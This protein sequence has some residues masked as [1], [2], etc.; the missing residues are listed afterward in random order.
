MKKASASKKVKSP[1]KRRAAAISKTVPKTK[2]IPARKTAAKISG[3]EELLNSIFEN[4]EGS[5]WLV[6]HQGKLVLFNKNF[7]D[8]Y[9]L[10]SGKTPVPGLDVYRYFPEPEK[11]YCDKQLLNALKGEKIVYEP[12]YPVKGKNHYFRTSLNP[13]FKAGKVTGVSC[14]SIEITN[15]KL[16][17]VAIYESEQRYRAL[18]EHA[19]DGIF[20]VN[21]DTTFMD[22]NTSA[23]KMLGYTREELLRMNIGDLYTKDEL[24]KNP[25]QWEQL[26]QNKSLLSERRLRKKDGSWIEVEINSRLQDG[27]GFLA[28]VRDITERK[29]IEEQLRENKQQLTLFIE[30]SPVALAMFDTEMRYLATSKRW[31]TDYHLENADLLGKSHYQIVPNLPQRWKD[32]HQRCLKGAVE[33]S[34]EDFYTDENGVDHWLR[35]EIRPWYK[36]SGKIGGMVMFTEFI[37]E[38][39]KAEAEVIRAYREKETVLNRISDSVVSLDNKWRYTFLN[40]EALA[41]HPGGREGT[42]GKSIWEVHPEM[43]GTIFWD[44]YHEAMETGKVT[45]IIDYYAPMDRWFSVRLFPSP[46]GLTIFYK[47]CT[48]TKRKEQEIAKE[49]NLSDSIINSLPGAFY[50]YD[51]AG[52][53]LRWNKNFETISGY[54]YQEVS[55]MH[56]L[57]FFDTDEKEMVANAIKQVLTQG[58]SEIEGNLKR[59]DGTKVAYYFNGH[60]A[61]F[62]GR[63]YVIGMGI[64]ITERQKAQQEILLEKS[65]SESIINSMPGI[66]YLANL[67][68]NFLRWNK[69]LETVTGYSAGEIANMRLR[70]F[71]S[72]EELE[73]M[74]AEKQKAIEKGATDVESLIQTKQGNKIPYFLTSRLASYNGTPC[75]LGVGVDITERKKAE[76]LI[77]K[78][79][80]KYRSLIEQ[81]SD[82]IMVTDFHG[83]F[84]DVNTSLCNTFGY[85]K[86]E[87]LKKNINSL[88]EPEELKE[89]PVRFDLLAAGQHVFNERR[90][91]RRD[92]SIVEVEA[93]VKKVDNDYV[94]AIA[95]DVTR[96]RQVQRDIQIS[97]A[98]FR[99]AFEFS[100][101][102]MAITSLEGK[103]IKVNN[104]MSQITGYTMEEM[105]RLSF[106]DITY[107][108][109]IEGDQQMTEELLAG[110]VDSFLREKRYLHK[111][112]YP[113]WVNVSVSLVKD[114]QGVPLYFVAQVEDINERKKAQDALQQSEARYRTL[115]ENAPEALVVLDLQLGKFVSVSDSAEE[116]YGLTKEELLKIGP[117]EVSPEY[118][119]DGRLSAESAME[120]INIAVAGGKPNFEWTHLHKSGRHVP[121]EIWLVRLPS[122]NQILI[123]GSIVDISERKQVEQDKEHARYLLNERVKELTTLY[124]TGRIL[125]T[126]Q[127]TDIALQEIADIIPAGWQFP[128]ICGACITL[129]MNAFK[130]ANFKPGGF[131]Q[132]AEFATT[133]GLH[134]SIEVIYLEQRPQEAEGPFLAEERNLINMLAEMIR[135]Y[136]NQK[137]ESEELNESYKQLRQLS[138]HLQTIREEERAIISR[139]IHDEL[140]QQL[141]GL[142]MDTAWLKKKV[143]EQDKDAREKIEDMLSLIDSTVTTVRRISSELRPGVLDDLGLVAALEWQS[144]E[145]EKRTGITSTFRAPELELEFEKEIAIGIF[146]IYQETL[147]NIVRHA[148]ATKLETTLER[149]GNN[150]ILHIKDNGNGFDMAEAKSKKTLGLVG[151]KE[152]ALMFNGELL[153]ESEKNRGTTITVK[154]PLTS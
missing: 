58:S 149:S 83:N 22:V 73:K 6:D 21:P 132:K 76:A 78:N 10:I 35:W 32:A 153:V 95:R 94:M 150:V 46:D 28:I 49:K 128:E 146:R 55:N 53:F 54:T 139:E 120:K 2:K 9:K 30:H 13:I 122:E 108:E 143:D 69:N 40:D 7:I 19:G 23:C 37:T 147:T 112:G 57:D 142:K 42:L 102:G 135:V 106:K 51:N 52:R 20:L 43:K 27:K 81:A 119:P 97:E 145:F 11:H 44:K 111:N 68:G 17:A 125:Q 71:V 137:Y 31:L 109:D 70:E 87:L 4:V 80:Q 8:A 99:G 134:G 15:T 63:D 34:E 67:E 85:T 59:K 41:T 84:V 90:M 56:P 105:L 130:T 29:K 138:S 116:L 93:N 45:E 140:G 152:R 91:M 103:W 62:E 148:H 101:I 104:R 18:V 1:A 3:T 121:C 74:L 129:G 25:L 72:M 127:A 38:R 33:K 16:A 65:L 14:Y 118:Q 126:E 96:L 114:P 115:V 131:S 89:R 61:Q 88:I 133:E 117:I 136:L 66:F 47:D 48:E 26:R 123:R 98:R 79:E 64:D 124:Q 75:I 151:M 86:E 92:G 82:P 100:A 39:K 110:K 12:V 107:P 24:E 154:I 144:S 113:V 141:T 5:A 60:R 36:G 77:V 50:L